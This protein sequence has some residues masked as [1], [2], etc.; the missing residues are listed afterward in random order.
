MYLNSHITSEC[1]GC[2]ACEQSCPKGCI[3]MQK[4]PE[5]FLYPV[6][7]EK[8]ALSVDCA[9]MCVRLRIISAKNRKIYATMDGTKMKKF[10]A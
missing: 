8:N 9:K 7:D 4:N 10:V 2:T 1:C 3:F 5:G 6:V